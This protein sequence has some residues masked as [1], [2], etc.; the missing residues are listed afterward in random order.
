[1]KLDKIKRRYD[2]IIIGCGL[3]G[4][5]L[6]L[7]LN[8][9]T[10]KSVLILEKKKKLEKDKSWCFWNYPLNPLTNKFDHKWKKIEIK[11]KTTQIIKSDDN[12]SYN[13]IY[14]KKLYDLILEKELKSDKLDILFSQD[15]EN[16]KNVDNENIIKLSSNKLI[17][18]ELIFDSRPPKIKQNKLVQHFLGIELESDKSIFDKEKV[19]LMDFPETKSDI[20]FFYIL[21]FTSKKALIESTYISEN[22]FNKENYINDIMSYVNNRYPD[23]KF[24]EKFREYGVIP[25]HQIDYKSKILSV[26]KIGT[27]DNWVRKSSGYAFQNAFINSK[28]IVEQIINNKTI[29]IKKKD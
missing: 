15:V 4:I 2:I 3:S 16:I 8:S 9:K 5:S 19:T 12:F 7:E 25:M 21:P 22:L 17:S 28:I 6:A 18:S 27:A 20:H 10:K 29:K 13:H 1:M 11:S 26:I 24:T 23:V 14:S